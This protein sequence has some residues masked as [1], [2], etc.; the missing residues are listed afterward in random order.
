MHSTRSSKIFHEVYLLRIPSILLNE[1]AIVMWADSPVFGVVV[2]VRIVF[3]VVGEEAIELYALLE[4]LNSLHA[5]DVLEEV[6]VTMDINA[7]SDKS[8]P[9][10][11]L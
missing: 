10:N 5:S 3:L 4:V 7:S 2:L 1:D 9:V 8:M 6:E 11:A